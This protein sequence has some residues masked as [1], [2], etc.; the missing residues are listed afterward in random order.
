[1]YSSL[2]QFQWNIKISL[3]IWNPNS[4][5]LDALAFETIRVTTRKV[6]QAEKWGGQ[7]R[8]T[9]RKCLLAG[10]FFFPFNPSS[11]WTG[12]PNDVIFSFSTCHH[13]L[14]SPVLF[15]KNRVLIIARVPA[16]KEIIIIKPQKY[17]FLFGCLC[18]RAF[19]PLDRR[20]ATRINIDV[21]NISFSL[22]FGIN[23]KTITYFPC[24][25]T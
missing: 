3:F 16:S 8:R 14:P 25:M 9:A 24:G 1:M 4:S 17:G 11:I 10:G 15:K 12:C 7:Q 22:S 18:V 5:L 23:F 13:H 21:R 19:L 6:N 20:A 2:K